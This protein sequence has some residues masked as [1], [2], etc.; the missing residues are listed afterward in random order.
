MR[1]EMH[2][3]VVEALSVAETTRPFWPSGCAQPRPAGAAGYENPRPKFRA[4]CPNSLAI[5][6]LSVGSHI[7]KYLLGMEA[8]I[9]YQSSKRDLKAD[10][11]YNHRRKIDAYSQ[12]SPIGSVYG[13]H[14]VFRR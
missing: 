10:T 14:R 7:A 13:K 8:I 6:R 1:L 12:Q 5:L 11:E 4:N 2:A 3:N 9:N